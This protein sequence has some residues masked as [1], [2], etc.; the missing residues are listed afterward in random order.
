M[1]VL[2][3][4]R[5]SVFWQL[6][7]QVSPVLNNFVIITHARLRVQIKDGEWDFATQ[8]EYAGATDKLIHSAS[9]LE[10]KNKM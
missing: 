5:K 7:T 9:A 2:A 4:C 3:N 6:W 8:R 1:E 10:W